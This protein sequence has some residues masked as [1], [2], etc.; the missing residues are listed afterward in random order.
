[1]NRADYDFSGWATRNDLLCIDGRTIRRDAFKDD[2]GKTVPL[3]WQHQHDSPANVIGHAL[4]MND[5]AGVRAFGKFNESQLGRHCK[6]L[7]RHGDITAL[8]IYANN[9]TQDG[10]NVTH[11]VIRELS[12]VLAGANPGAVID[13][14]VLAHGEESMLE[15]QI[16]TGMPVEA[17]DDIS[18][19]DNSDKK[20][21]DNKEATEM[22]DKE[23][24]VKDVF[25]SMNEEQKKVVYYMVAKAAEAGN[26]ADDDDEEETEMKHNVFDNENQDNVLSHDAMKE[27]IADVKRYGTLKESCLQHGIEDLRVEGTETYG[28]KGISA[29]FPDAKNVTTTPEFIARDDAWV[30]EVL[31]GT[32]HT[33]FSRIKSLFADITEDEA[34]AKGYIKGKKKKDEVFGLLKRT[35]TPVTVYKKQKFDR[36]DMI[37]IVDFYVVSWIRGEMRVMLNEELAR[38]ILVGDGRNPSSDDKIS[39][40]NIR[41]I[42]TDDSLF[43]IKAFVQVGAGMTADARAKAFEQA[44]IRARNDYKGSGNPVM[45]TSD[46]VLTDL[47]LR[48]DT[49]GRRIYAS[50]T[51]LATALLVKKIVTVPVMR[52]LTRTDSDDGKVH[53]LMGIVVDLKDYNVGADKGGAVSMFDDFDIDY[54]AQKYLI[55][56]RCSGALIKPYSAIA[57]EAVPSEG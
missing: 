37:D 16:F 8:S 30:S 45:F 15:A 29:L 47:L 44:A 46:E 42:W 54:N 48:E 27:I 6:E 4:L 38:A 22:A 56:T 9:L 34:R 57:I 55:E 24:T 5:E 26:S 39:E 23:K 12:I 36:D 31:N 51:E 53:T 21:T 28:V 20:D 11:G 32:H 50:I 41:P 3:V 18:H 13:Y 52:N 33:P 19:A 17:I 14:P 1:M 40:S 25:E 10:G 43:T 2:D 7:V 49:T 35:T